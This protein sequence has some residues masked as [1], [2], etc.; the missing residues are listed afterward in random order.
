MPVGATIGV[1]WYY[2]LNY[3]SNDFFA[4]LIIIIIKLL[5]YENIWEFKYFLRES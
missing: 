3:Y 2:D 1:V 4:I 5:E